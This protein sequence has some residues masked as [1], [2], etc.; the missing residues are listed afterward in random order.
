MTK[1]TVVWT[2]KTLK[3]ALG[4]EVPLGIEGFRVQFNSKDVNEGDVF[5][6]LKGDNG[7][8]HQYV[9]NALEM[10]AACAIVS[11]FNLAGSHPGLEPGSHEFPGIPG[12]ARDD[13]LIARNGIIKVE[14]TFEALHKLAKYK[15]D[16]S[17]A[18]FIAITGSIGKTSTKESIA[19]VLKVYGKSMATRGNFNNHI[20]VPLD[21]ASMPDDLEYAV[22]EMGMEHPGEISHLSKMVKPD[23]ALITTISLIHLVFF[24]SEQ[25]IAD[26]KCEI[27][28]G[29]TSDGVVLLN[30]D[31]KHY[32]YCAKKASHLNIS[33]FGTSD[34]ADYRVA[35]YSFDGVVAHMDFTLHNQTYAA[36]T[37]LVGRHMATNLTA[38]LGIS[39]LLGL[40]TEGVLEVMKDLAPKRGRGEQITLTLNGHKCTLIHDCYNAEPAS[41][42]AALE[43]MKDIKHDNKIAILA[44]MRW[45]G[46]TEIQHHLSL[47]D[48]VLEAGINKLYTVGGLMVHLH[49]KL[50]D[51]IEC[52]H[53]ETSAELQ[54]EVLNL[55]NDDSLILIKGSNIMGLLNVAGY[56][57]NEGSKS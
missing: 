19:A 49:K 54:K 27:F 26:A 39:D 16:K 47:V 33:T 4:V 45:L 43:H 48:Y 56:L 24:T 32:E 35:N 10:G 20:G 21:L 51:T 34:K 50:T 29:M 11:Q 53:F 28:D 18:K 41:V 12:Q 6:A 38:V 9:T 52:K 40:P 7:D 17:N 23:I 1:E 37:K 22:F 30:C 14:D 15:R 31:N 42:K 36:T 3:E 13:Q 5:I 57:I 55:I 44:D 46:D 25:G 8:G 2:S